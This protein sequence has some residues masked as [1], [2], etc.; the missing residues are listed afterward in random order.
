MKLATDTQAK[1]RRHL[2]LV[3]EWQRAINLIGPSTIGNAW[4]RHTEDS[5]SL[6]PFIPPETKCIMDVGSGAGFPGMCIAICRPDI[7]IHLVEKD[8]KKAEFLRYVS[9]ETNTPVTI[10]QTRLE[11]IEGPK[12][13]IVT[14]RA[15]ATCE[16]ILDLTQKFHRPSLSYLLLKGPDVKKELDIVKNNWHFPYHYTTTIHVPRETPSALEGGCI[17][18][19]TLQD[20]GPCPTK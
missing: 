10:H 7:Q 5:L 14:A 3:L 17:V 13:D 9:R 20:S 16:A 19:L 6:L 4:H 8:G 18:N 15:F 1:L 12:P 11:Q 2:D